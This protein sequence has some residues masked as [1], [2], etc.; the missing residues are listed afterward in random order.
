MLVFCLEI[1]TCN[2]NIEMVE[3]YNK[4]MNNWVWSLDIWQHF[5]VNIIFLDLFLDPG[6]G[7]WNM[8]SIR[9]YFLWIF[10]E[11]LNIKILVW[12]YFWWDI[13]GQ[14]RATHTASTLLIYFDVYWMCKRV[15]RISELKLRKKALKYII[16]NV[17][18]IYIYLFP[19]AVFVCC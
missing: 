1:I 19:N 13:K 18:R 12:F 14:E 9:N 16:I 8:F 5:K 15:L 2:N 17:T 11:I 6:M 4:K 3:I 7:D 10:W